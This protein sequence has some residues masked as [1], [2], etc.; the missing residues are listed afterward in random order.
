MIKELR[1]YYHS[2]KIFKFFINHSYV[3]ESICRDLL[4]KRL[5]A[6]S[7]IKPR[8]IVLKLHSSCNAKC[9]YCYAR[10]DRRNDRNTLTLDDWKDL[11][12][13]AKNLGCYT[14][15]LSGGE[16]MIYPYLAELVGYI[17]MKKMIPFTSTN[18]L[19]AT[20]AILR[21]L[22]RAGL[23]A[24]NWSILGPRKYHDRI[25]GINGAFDKIIEHG[26]YCA[27]KTKIVCL[28]NHV[29]TRESIRNKWYSH[30]WD[31]MKPRGFRALNLL[32]VCIN[33]LDKSILLESGDLLIY[34]QLAEK[35]YVLMDTKNY[36]TP[37]CPAGREDLFVNDFGEVQ[38]CPFIPVTFGNIREYSLKELF[39]RIQSHP[40]FR[41]RRHVCMPARDPD[42]ID[43]YIL[44]AFRNSELPANVDDIWRE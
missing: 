6:G 26:E 42:F 15:T 2:G 43:R 19:A 5:N 22:E 29:A 33:S 13:Q 34:D 1:R 35:N 31:L 37:M 11:I 23:C 36:S 18:G 9:K 7:Y 40:V 41:V 8:N 30:V 14:V 25:A 44:P 32:P 24:L 21:E 12:N 27:R 39:V 17:R 16:P 20:P 10:K 3:Y 38:P 28:V 4:E